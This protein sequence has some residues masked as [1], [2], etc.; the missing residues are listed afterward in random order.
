MTPEQAI[1]AL[2]Q[3]NGELFRDRLTVDAIITELLDDN[4][5]DDVARAYGLAVERCGLL[6]EWR[7]ERET[8]NEDID[9]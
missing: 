7:S 9:P 5:F 4:G 1:V 6:C 2:A 8:A 3:I